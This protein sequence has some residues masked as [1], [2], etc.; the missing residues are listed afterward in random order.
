MSFVNIEC[1]TPFKITIN[2][3]IAISGILNLKIRTI[4]RGYEQDLKLKYILG[5]YKP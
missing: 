2:R 5:T 4:K 3:N 1:Y